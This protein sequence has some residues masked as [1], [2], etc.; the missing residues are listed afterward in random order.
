MKQRQRMNKGSMTGRMLLVIAS[1][2]DENGEFSL[3][4]AISAVE[5][6]YPSMATLYS[7]PIGNLITGLRRQGY[8]EHAE[9]YAR[10][11]LPWSTLDF[12]EA[13]GFPMERLV[14]L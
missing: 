11:R 1:I 8:T 14:S 6:A 5:R 4:D 9:G 13:N 7:S 2:A 12:M 3:Q 10:Y